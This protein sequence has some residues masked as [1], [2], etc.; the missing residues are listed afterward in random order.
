MKPS[1]PS[2]PVLPVSWGEV[3]DKLT[4]LEIKLNALAGEAQRANVAREKAAIEAVIGNRQRFPPGLESLVQTLQDINRDLWGIEDG[5]RACEQ[6]G[7][8]DAH[9]VQLA[10]DV[11]LKNDRRAQIKRQINVLLGS[12]LVEEK[13][14][15]GAV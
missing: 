13:S 7:R 4:I 2:I 5:K 1:W 15:H 6:A 12:G 11:Y 10:R 14:H 8:F 9:F 3:F